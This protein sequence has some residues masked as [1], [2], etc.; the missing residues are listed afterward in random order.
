M[1]NKTVWNAVLGSQNRQND[2]CSFPR[3]TIQITVIQAYAPT[4]NTEEAEV[5][6]F[7]E[8]LQDLLELT[9]T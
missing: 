6:L 1:V 7:S 8:D 3:Q 4:N 9:N 2:L 5:E